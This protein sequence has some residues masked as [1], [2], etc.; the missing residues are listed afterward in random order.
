MR[1]APSLVI[2]PALQA[3]GATLRGYDPAGMTEAGKLLGDVA[4][5]AD[6]YS[7]LQD[8]DALVIMTEWNEFRALDLARVREALK[9]PIVVDMRNI[10]DP[11][12]MRELGFR[13]SCVGRAV[14]GSGPAR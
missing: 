12:E 7:A 6:A 11:A 3:A 14:D 5:C 1:D 8:A 9:T 13:Y 10:Y 4:W 2:V